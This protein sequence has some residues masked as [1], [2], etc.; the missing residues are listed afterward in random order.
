[1]DNVL[2]MLL[3]FA[4]HAD[5]ACKIIRNIVD[6]VVGIQSTRSIT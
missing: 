4:T 5:Q 6:I 1:M 2:T 3:M